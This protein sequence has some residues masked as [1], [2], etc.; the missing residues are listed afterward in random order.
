MNEDKY[1]VVPVGGYQCVECGSIS[2]DVEDDPVYECGNCG[3]KWTRDGAYSSPA[4]KCPDCNKFASRIAD[5]GCQECQAGEM[6][7][8][9]LYEIDGGDSEELYETEQDAQDALKAL[10]ADDT[11]AVQP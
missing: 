1:E 3:T 10:L 5:H 7:E 9:E 6:E 4:H 2:R 11:P 8:A